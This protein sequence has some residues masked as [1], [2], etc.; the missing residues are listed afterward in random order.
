MVLADG[1]EGPGFVIAEV[2]LAEA[3]KARSMIAALEHD[4]AFSLEQAPPLKEV[5]AS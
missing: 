4:R 1:G 2:N 3:D 5:A